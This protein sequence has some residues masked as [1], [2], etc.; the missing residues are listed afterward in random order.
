MRK[1]SLTPY[2]SFD[3]HDYVL[4][5]VP[6]TAKQISK[7]KTAHRKS[8]NAHKRRKGK[9][10]NKSSGKQ[11]PCPEDA[12]ATSTPEPEGSV[13]TQ[14]PAVTTPPP[15]ISPTTTPPQISPTTEPT[16]VSPPTLETEIAPTSRPI[17]SGDFETTLNLD[18]VPS[19]YHSAFRNAAAKWDSIIVGDLEDYP[20]FDEDRTN[21]ELICDGDS[22][23]E[24]VDDVFICASLPEI[25]GPSGILGS[26][27]PIYG[28]IGDFVQTSVGYMQFDLADVAILAAQGRLDGLIVSQKSASQM[29]NKWTSMA[30]FFVLVS[31][32]SKISYMKWRMW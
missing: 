27:G 29:G 18:Q 19:E 5:I 15:Q 7:S 25:D 26:A 28:R 11:T 4:S 17:T 16:L 13:S 24:I 3:E 12:V 21:P 2:G 31:P 22:L 1:R 8:A 9:G 14:S 23:P 20:I 10:R 32:V 6:A 30:H